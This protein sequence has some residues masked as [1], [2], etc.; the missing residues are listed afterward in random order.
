MIPQRCISAPGEAGDCVRACVA[1]VLGVPAATMPNF[2]ELTKRE[3]LEGEKAYLA[4]QQQIRD[5]LRPLGLSIFNSYCNGEWPL[6]KALD[7]FSGFSPG[8][9]IIF[10]G[11]A[12]SRPDEHHAVIA[13]DG[14]I[15]HDPSGAGIAGPCGEWWYMDVI[16]L[17]AD[18]TARRDRDATLA[19]TTEELAPGEAS[20]PGPK[21]S[22]K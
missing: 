17:G 14:K 7:Y 3:G 4:M 15:V 22:P 13:L 2:N 21:A 8:V 16:G 19:E 5:F 1:T 20:Q 9:P 11:Q 18:W 6:E 10:H 12:L